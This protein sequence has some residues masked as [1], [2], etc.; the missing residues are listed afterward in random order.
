M[1]LATT[2]ILSTLALA[3]TSVF[4]APMP[5]GK[6][7]D[8]LQNNVHIHKQEQQTQNVLGKETQTHE[9][10]QQHQHVLV[11]KDKRSDEP[12]NIVNVQQADESSTA[13][14]SELSKRGWDWD[15]MF[16]FDW[17]DM[18]KFRRYPYG[19]YGGYYPGYGGYAGY[20]YGSGYYSPYGYSYGYPYYWD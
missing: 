12:D 10:Q 2:A 15:D 3:S 14:E 9:Q 7:A 17:D 6:H 19:G 4:A 20:G 18:Y 16:D 5:H 11:N 1:K 13:D 8:T